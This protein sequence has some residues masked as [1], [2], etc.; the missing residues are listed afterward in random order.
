MLRD[1]MPGR[2][3]SKSRLAS[4]MLAVLLLAGAV[5]QANP[6]DIRHRLGNGLVELQFTQEDPANGDDLWLTRITAP[7]G[8]I[9][10]LEKGLPLWE[11]EARIDPTVPANAAYDLS[12]VPDDLPLVSVQ[13]FNVGTFPGQTYRYL[14]ATWGPGSVPVAGGAPT[15]NPNVTVTATWILPYGSDTAE[16]HLNVSLNNPG[17]TTYRL[18]LTRYPRLAVRSLDIADGDDGNGSDRLATGRV[19]G[20]LYG[21]PIG[22]VDPVSGQPLLLTQDPDHQINVVSPDSIDPGTLSVPVSAYY[23]QTTG[24]GL[25]HANNDDEGYVKGIYWTQ[26]PALGTAGSMVVET[27]QFVTGNVFDATSYTSPYHVQIA[28]FENGDW[29]TAAH[30]YRE[31]YRTYPWYT[32]P[33]GASSNLSVPLA[34]KTNPL[35]GWIETGNGYCPETFDLTTASAELSFF[36][37]HFGQPFPML[38]FNRFVVDPMSEVTLAGGY[39]QNPSPPMSAVHQFVTS[40]ENAGN[41]V[42]VHAMT[43]KIS[44]TPTDSK[45]TIFASCLGGGYCA[46]LDPSMVQMVQENGLWL[47]PNVGPVGIACAA[48]KGSPSG[49][50]IDWPTWFSGVSASFLNTLG[51]SGG[52]GWPSPNPF[53]GWCFATTHDHDPGFGSFYAQAWLSM[54]DDVAAQTTVSPVPT[55]ME[56]S[57]AF[58]SQKVPVQNPWALDWSYEP[59]HVLDQASSQTWYEYHDAYIRRI[60]MLPMAADNLRYGSVYDPSFCAMPYTRLLTANPGDQFFEPFPAITA[61]L[62]CWQMGIRVL[63][64]QGSVFISNRFMVSP[65]DVQS[66]GLDEAK[67]AA[68]DLYDYYRS[69][70][71][72]LTASSPAPLM[73]YHAG[74]LERAPDVTVIGATQDVVLDQ[75]VVQGFLPNLWSYFSTYLGVGS[76][77]ITELDFSQYEPIKHLVGLNAFF[78]PTWIPVSAD[79]NPTWLPRGM[80]RHHN[81]GSL[82][83]LMSNPWGAE[84]YDANTATSTPMNPFSFDYSN[85]P[86]SPSNTYAYSYSFDPADY[87]GFPSTYQ[88]AFAVY[89]VT[90]TLVSQSSFQPAS[91][92]QNFAGTLGP[93]QSVAWVFKP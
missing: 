75:S 2:L 39:A 55:I 9:V 32:G 70:S 56:T 23:D 40:A 60:P 71:D 83:L 46:Q 57:S 37:N 67:L 86:A 38:M 88:V 20:T 78:G 3:D 84:H 10:S 25:Y 7:T 33:I 77:Q 21:D 12:I 80:Y 90:G 35:F 27:I 8:G 6:A 61:A 43:E 68:V 82:A 69:L 31:Q 13:I 59:N 47:K 42:T 52:Q 93:F 65:Q 64:H 66:P 76:N 15:G 48:G 50:N 91:G 74:S 1:S 89:D 51:A 54:L 79:E 44:V 11:V 92:M 36:N 49:T 28:A 30:K 29:I 19:G 41:K 22:Y 18:W 16:A 4:A 34:L 53:S 58:F 63:E 62:G 24:L 14:V 72:F 5:V 26:D 73:D 17:A 81:G 87:A 85:P 45:C